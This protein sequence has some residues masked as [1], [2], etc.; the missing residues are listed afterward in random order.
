MGMIFNSSTGKYDFVYDPQSSPEQNAQV[1]SRVDAANADVSK[2]TNYHPSTSGGTAIGAWEG[3]VSS[4]SSSGTGSS[5][6]GGGTSGVGSGS[7]NSAITGLTS[8]LSGGGMGAGA[9]SKVAP[10]LDTKPDMGGQASSGGIGG[11]ISPGGD[12][13][14][15]PAVSSP[16]M[17]GLNLRNGLGNRLYPNENSPLAALRKIY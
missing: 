8:A 3:H 9:P 14:S 15:T 5:S 6:G 1:Q 13:G 7:I 16:A 10:V 11:S 4:P 12:S 17:A 2:Q